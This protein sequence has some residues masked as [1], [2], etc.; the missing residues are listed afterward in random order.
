MPTL[1]R[2][3]RT[4][5][6]I[7]AILAVLFLVAM[8]LPGAVLAAAPTVIPAT[9][10]GAISADTAAIPP[11]SGAYTTLAGP[12][13]SGAGA[14]DIGAGPLTF[15][16]AG[17]FEFQAGAGS[18]VLSGGAGCGTLVLGAAT[19]T[20]SAASVTT[21][22]ASTGACSIVFSGLRVRPSGAGTPLATGSI[23]ASG[24][25]TGA[26]GVLG[27]VPGAA[28]LSYQLPLPSTSATA[29]TA[30]SQQPIVLS[31]DKFGNPREADSITLTSV[32]AA[33]GFSCTLNPKPTS[34]SGLVT[35]AGCTFTSQ[36]SYQIQAS[37][38]GGT[39]VVSATITVAAAPATKLVITTQPGHGIP[40]SQLASQ[41]V[42]A[43][44]D[45]FGNTVTSAS[46]TILLSIVAPDLG[47]PGVLIGC[48]TAPTVNGVST[49]SGCR[50][51]TVGVGYR[52]IA[53]DN[54]G[55]GAPHPYTLATSTK[56]D[57][58]DRI[59]FT[60]QPSGATAGTAFT[61]QPVVAVRA[62]ASNTA[63][64]DSTTAVTLALSGGPIGATLTGCTSN[65]LTVSAGVASFS[66]C[67]ID[68]IGT[69]TLV[70]SSGNLGTVTS[71]SFT[72]AAGP[73]TK[74]ASP[75]SPRLR[76]RPSHSRS[77][78]SLRSR[79]RVATR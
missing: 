26:A 64:N 43:I 72:V 17:A 15:T 47:G 11:G 61:T 37:T 49:F 30:L 25:A 75:P 33:G 9:G 14:G 50:I 70:A 69:Y 19:V 5:S 38:A 76:R 22:G 54:T 53:S 12:S 57:V 78:R 45:S 16:I 41:P 35:F 66:G 51:D 10:G 65:P 2:K 6:R 32:P 18:A 58:R 62:G 44:Q 56:F 55:G 34:A 63:T 20:S 1:N 77:S 60:T 40:S 27:M 48:S 71:S 46:A 68:K 4:T 73:A 79:M 31:A 59:V 36:G 39:P 42:V 3:P 24:L 13:I 52:L 28:L 23:A 67:K 29:G 8:L 21:A 74:L 7:G